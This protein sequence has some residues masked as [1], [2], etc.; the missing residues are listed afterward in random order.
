MDATLE[1]L[2][3]I[4]LRGLPTFFLVLLLHFYLKSTYFGPIEK[5]LKDRYDATEGARKGALEALARAEAK[6][7]E[8]EAAIQNARTE[9]YR[10]NELSR[11]VLSDEVSAR[12]AEERAAAD[13]KVAEAKAT[14]AAEVAVA[15]QGLFAES[16]VVA[17]AITERI[18]GRAV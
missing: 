16:D 7:A 14:I 9:I 17:N 15:R 8:Y 5:V 12:L 3:N 1:A 10:A 18:L 2:Y 6:A 11:K 13:T 4:V